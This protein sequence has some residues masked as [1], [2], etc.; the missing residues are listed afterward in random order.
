MALLVSITATSR[1]LPPPPPLSSSCLA[2]STMN[3]G[4]LFPQNFWY[5]PHSPLDSRYPTPSPLSIVCYYNRHYRTPFA[6]TSATSNTIHPYHHENTPPLPA[7]FITI[8][9]TTEPQYRR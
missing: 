3:I 4:H 5:P 8:A 7:S 2:P 6:I 1:N 9:S